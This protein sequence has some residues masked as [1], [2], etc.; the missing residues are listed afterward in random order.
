MIVCRSRSGGVIRGLDSGYDEDDDD[1]ND[2][3]EGVIDVSSCCCFCHF[4]WDLKDN[5]EDKLINFKQ[6]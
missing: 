1:E 6:N 3:D 2:D 4:T 5:N